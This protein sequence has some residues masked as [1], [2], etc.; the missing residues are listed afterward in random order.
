VELLRRVFRPV[1]LT[2]NLP[3]FTA[4][5][6]YHGFDDG[7]TYIVKDDTGQETAIECEFAKEQS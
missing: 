7:K 4:G 2:V 5:E 1:L 3:S 6:K